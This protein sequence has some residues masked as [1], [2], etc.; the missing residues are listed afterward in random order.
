VETGRLKLNLG[1]VS[2]AEAAQEA[3][4]SLKSQIEGKGQ[5]LT[6]ALAPDLPPVHADQARVQQILANLLSNAHKYSPPA[7][8]ITL[9]AERA[10]SHVRVSVADAGYGIAPADQ[11]KLF[12]QFFRSDDPNVREQN[13][14]GL[15]LHVT[16][17]LVELQGGQIAA[18]SELGQGST[19]AFTLPLLPIA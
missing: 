5:T 19:F 3:V 17:L 14:W 8:A 12:S 4:D 11:A 18:Q 1:P 2:V 9:A 10:G 15:G 6:L 16:K 13:G 7:A